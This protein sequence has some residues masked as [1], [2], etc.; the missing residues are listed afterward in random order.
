MG[1]FANSLH[2]KSG[3][4]NRVASKLTDI[5]A[6]SGWRPTAATPD[7]RTD[8]PGPSTLRGM[9]ISAP[10][11]GW[12]TVLDSDLGG[13]YSL[14]GEL[15]QSLESHAIC[16][17]VNDSDS[18][19]YRLSDPKGR[20]SEFDSDEEADGDGDEGD[21]VEA[22]AMIGQLQSLM[23]DGSVLQRFQEM[24]ARMSEAAPPEIKAAEA[25]I[26][27]GQ[28]TAADMRQYQT[29][30][31]GEMPKYMAEMR[32]MLAGALNPLK[33]LSA[34][35]STRKKQRK[36]TKA[37]RAAARERLDRLRPILA[38]GVTD[39]AVLEA[40]DKRATFAENVLAEFLPLVGIADYYANLGYQYL[41]EIRP[42]ELAAHNIRFVQHLRFET[43]AK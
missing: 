30:A 22:G 3:D 27:S 36:S 13:A 18:W 5:L 29:W 39:E 12:V 26:K 34:A 37:E 6:S 17:L 24:Q 38:D 21:L 11:E 10:H 33:A 41:D 31:T 25:R 40:F 35:A 19:S 15:A 2:V 4:P 32:Q 16:F 8:W 14:V 20:I 43:S 7:K 23:R 28:G 9:H 42:A 1:S